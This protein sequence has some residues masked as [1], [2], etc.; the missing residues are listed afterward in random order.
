MTSK[1]RGWIFLPPSF[2]RFNLVPI[3]DFQG[4]EHFNELYEH[5]PVRDKIK[6]IFKRLS[7][8]LIELISLNMSK[9]RKQN[10]ETNNAAGQK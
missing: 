5:E 4:S 6:F 3:C 10:K 8:A 1:E 7:C 2:I 9:K